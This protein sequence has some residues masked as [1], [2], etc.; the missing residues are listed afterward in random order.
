MSL[1]REVQN[2][3]ASAGVDV[4]TVLLKCKILAA[5][6]GSEEFSSWVNWEPNG[7]PE[8]QTTPNY[9]R[10]VAHGCANL[11]NSAWQAT[12]QPVMWELLP[13]EALGPHR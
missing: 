10:L 12:K 13:L 6:L 5:R 9:R 2:D 1:L 8:S 7:H 4:T 11:M 3:L